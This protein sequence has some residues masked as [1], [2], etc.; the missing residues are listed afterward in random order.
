MTSSRFS[1]PR[2]TTCSP[3]AGY[4]L[5]LGR[6]GPLLSA[7]DVVFVPGLNEESAATAMQA[8]IRTAIDR[9]GRLLG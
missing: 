9:P 8:E 3:Q 7:N 4:D 5:E 1:G 6:V 2:D